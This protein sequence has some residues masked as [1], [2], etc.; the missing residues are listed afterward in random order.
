[1]NLLRKVLFVAVLII[2][3]CIAAVFAYNNPEPVTVDIGVARFDDISLTLALACAFAL[4]WVVGLASAGLALIRMVAEKRR[5]R[6][7]LR[8]A[9]TE[10]ASL[11]TLPMNDAN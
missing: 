4:G 5:I 8:T 9:E 3:V 1:M 2:L 11:R 10:V 6:R 7:Q